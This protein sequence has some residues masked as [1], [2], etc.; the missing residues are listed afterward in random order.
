M[1]KL[2]VF[3]CLSTLFGIFLLN[4]GCISKNKL[5]IYQIDNDSTVEYSKRKLAEYYADHDSTAIYSTHPSRPFKYGYAYT[6]EECK[7]YLSEYLTEYKFKKGDVIADIGA[8]SGWKDA[9]FSVLVDSMTFYIEDI[10]TDCL[11]K[12]QFEKVLNH[13][14]K[15]RE[16]PQT[17]KFHFVIGNQIETNLPDSIFD[18]IIFDNSFHEIYYLTDLL[19]DV[20]DKIKP[21]G[22]IIIRDG[23]S[24]KYKNTHLRGC[25]IKG[26]KVSYVVKLL[27]Q[28][29][30]YLTNMTNPECSFSN[31]L[32]FEQ[33]ARKAFAFQ[34]KIKTVEPYANELY[35]LFKKKISR[36]STK[37]IEIANFL[38]E[39]SKEICKIY[40]SLESGIYELGYEWLRDKE[41]QA[42]INVFKVNVTLYPSSSNA[43]YSLGEAYMLNGQYKLALAN[44]Y[45][46]NELFPE[47]K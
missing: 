16:T 47:K 42:A 34:R 36:D 19:E 46:S 9:A 24:N 10:D 14:N 12:S 26:Y 41:Y 32:T 29:G 8:A 45:K 23:F 11:N 3:I 25:D 5:A 4:T 39:H 27:E 2:L 21:N 22:Q 31:N 15:V 35:K 7:E 30:F 33:D 38:K 37:T 44:Y 6:K 1:N 13:Y 18:K 40:S 28:Q 43:Y 17:N 20:Y